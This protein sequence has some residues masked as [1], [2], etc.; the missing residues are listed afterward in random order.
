L[1]GIRRRLHQLG[2]GTDLSM[3]HV[4]GLIGLA[5]EHWTVLRLVTHPIHDDDL[6]RQAWE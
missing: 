3:S 2:L 6:G 4:G 5:T 1:K